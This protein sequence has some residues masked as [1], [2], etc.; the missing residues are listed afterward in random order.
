VL[1]KI[2]TYKDLDGKEVTDEFYFH[3][4][5]SELVK[6]QV[7]AGEGFRDYLMKIVAS[8][9]GAKIIEEFENILR[10]AYGVR[11][12]DGK[13]FLKPPGA[14]EAFQGTD[15]YDQLFMQLVTDAKASAEFVNGV[16]PSELALEAEKLN[17][18]TGN[19]P[20][21]EE[22]EDKR[23]LW[24][25]ENRD[26]NPQEIRNMSTAELADAMK[27]RVQKTAGD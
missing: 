12:P 7:S 14:F 8:G 21:M 25:R 10:L 19:K 11:S 16:V 5:K 20:T 23:P 4:S 1:K 15:A 18:L 24:E 2:I 3:I 27:R 17:A 22:Q 9:D 26:P 13:S 6:L